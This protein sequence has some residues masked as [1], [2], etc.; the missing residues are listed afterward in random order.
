M[1]EPRQEDWFVWTGKSVPLAAA[2]AWLVAPWALAGCA[3]R[4]VQVG[5]MGVRPPNLKAPFELSPLSEAANPAV[6]RLR[7]RGVLGETVQSSPHRLEVALWTWDRRR[8]LG[9]CAVPDPVSRE[10]CARWISPPVR[11]RGPFAPTVAYGLDLRL[12]DRPTGEVVYAIDT[13][14][15]GGRRPPPAVERRLVDAA[16][17]CAG[18]AGGSLAGL[19]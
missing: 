9:V 14:L 5:D 19:P 18:C 2:A 15:N 16:V 11:S 17:K 3:E 8:G 12:I 1:C 10:R 4:P 6:A 13:R 7:E